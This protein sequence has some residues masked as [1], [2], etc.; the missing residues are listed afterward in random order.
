MKVNY[1]YF[2]L[3]LFHYVI[4]NGHCQ[5]RIRLAIL[6]RFLGKNCLINRV[7]VCC[8][9]G[10]RSHTCIMTGE[11][12]INKWLAKSYPNKLLGSVMPDSSTSMPNLPRPLNFQPLYN[13]N[14]I[15]KTNEPVNNRLSS[16]FY[17]SLLNVKSLSSPLH[18]MWDMQ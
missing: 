9:L 18:H 3:F 17:Q 8:I 15:L 1:S 2:D 12:N 6:S 10:G 11:S 4:L 16:T 7:T 13:P 14:S 5:G